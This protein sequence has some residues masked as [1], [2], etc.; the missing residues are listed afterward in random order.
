M[1]ILPV[2]RL[3]NI[4]HEYYP[5]IVAQSTRKA[6]QKNLSD[7]WPWGYSLCFLSG[8]TAG[9]LAGQDRDANFRIV[10]I[11]LDC[12]PICALFGDLL[13]LSRKKLGEISLGY[14][15]CQS[16]LL[17]SHHGPSH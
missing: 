15:L 4:Q 13:S 5:T 10:P 12:R 6:S 14:R 1:R 9:V 7:R 11:I 2:E 17:F 8:C 3:D 16:P